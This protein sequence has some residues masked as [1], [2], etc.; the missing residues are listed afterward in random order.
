MEAEL[1]EKSSSGKE[2]KEEF[3]SLKQEYDLELNLLRKVTQTE[4]TKLKNEILAKDKELK[5][6]KEKMN[7]NETQMTEGR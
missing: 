7:M 1:K 2:Q 5:E 6:L 3:E 4:Q